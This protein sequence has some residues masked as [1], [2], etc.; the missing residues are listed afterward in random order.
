MALFVLH[1]VGESKRFDRI[2]GT[3]KLRGRNDQGEFGVS[4]LFSRSDQSAGTCGQCRTLY[5][6]HFVSKT[7]E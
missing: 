4:L 1:C 7:L 5:S 3:G 2:Y 6:M